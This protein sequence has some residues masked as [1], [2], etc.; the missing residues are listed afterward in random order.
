[1]LWQG[2]PFDQSNFF[3]VVK[4]LKKATFFGKF[5]APTPNKTEER[6]HGV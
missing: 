6:R 1:M 5:L 4:G 3:K 2:K